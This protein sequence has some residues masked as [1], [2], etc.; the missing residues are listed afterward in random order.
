[1]AYP[2][3]RAAWL[4]GPGRNAAAGTGSRIPPLGVSPPTR[5]TPSVA[6]PL[7]VLRWVSAGLL[8]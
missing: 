5:L 6:F 2:L 4:P 8:G 7:S 3:S 1:V